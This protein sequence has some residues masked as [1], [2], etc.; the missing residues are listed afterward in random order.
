[1][2]PK[3]SLQAVL[4]FRHSRVEGLEVSLGSLQAARLVAETRLE[5]LHEERLGLFEA[6]RRTQAGALD[7]GAIGHLR[8]SLK[9]LERRIEQ[10]EASLAELLLQIEQRR[11]E[12]VEAKQQEET[13]A[14][15]KAR[16][17]ERY[18]AV[19]AQQENRLRD[20]I[21]IARAFQQR[22]TP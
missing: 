4:D 21:Y 3:F 5:A 14:T 17:I 9:G 2:P 19:L 1:M 12:L 22:A 6:L 20:D 15:L 10:Q 13:L 11:L 18:Q 8:Q 7:L 16:E